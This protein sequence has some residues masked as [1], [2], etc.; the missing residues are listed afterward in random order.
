M[1]KK[2]KIDFT[3]CFGIKKLVHELSFEKGHVHL[4]YA[5]NGTMKTSFAKT[6]RYLSGQSKD[7]PCDLLHKERIASFSVTSDNNNI[8]E[9]N[10][11][12]INGDEELDS[13]KS[14]INFLA[15][16]EL[17]AKYDEIYQKL[18]NDKD[19]LMTK[20]KGISQSSNCE[21]EIVETFSTSENDSIFNILTRWRN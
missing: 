20:L 15:S 3:N 14:F 6:M 12:V 5:P 11:F 4:F 2:I 18:T 19:T 21:D 9:E 17:K 13:S 8:S 7:K 1:I 16:T 10:L